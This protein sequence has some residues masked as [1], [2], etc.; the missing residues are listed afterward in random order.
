MKKPVA[1]AAAGAAAALA[2]TVA[3]RTMRFKP[4][5]EPDAPTTPDIV[6]IDGQKA[7]DDLAA[8]IR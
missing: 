6:R 8:M 3:V 2:G 4:G 7:V 5:P 1:A